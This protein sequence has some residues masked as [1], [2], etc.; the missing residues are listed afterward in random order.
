MSV[1]AQRFTSRSAWCAAIARTVGDGARA[2][3]RAGRR[4]V[5]AFSGGTTPALYLPDLRRRAPVPWSASCL[6]LVDDRC[7]PALDR[8]SNEGLV[9]RHL[10]GWSPRP[11]G[12]EVVPLWRGPDG[13]GERRRRD[14]AI[15][16]VRPLD[17]AVLGLGTDGHIASL[18]PEHPELWHADGPTV[19]FRRPG[20]AFDRVSLTLDVL[21]EAKCLVVAVQGA[22]KWAVWERIRDGGSGSGSPLAALL[23]ARLGGHGMAARV[24]AL[25]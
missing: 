10:A 22:D 1:L 6:T 23:R 14:A 25:A 18:S 20:D 11:D 3:Y 8:R 4:P 9:K 7:V 16:A 12:P 21:A 15:E 24:L 5:L 19:R 17:V 2:A 13:I